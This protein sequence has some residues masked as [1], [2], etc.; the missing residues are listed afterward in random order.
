MAKRRENVVAFKR[1]F[2]AVPLRRIVNRPPKPPKWPATKP[3]RKPWRQAWSETR[4]FVLLIALVTIWYIAD[5]HSLVPTP[6]FLLT[7]HETVAGRFSRCGPGRSELCVIDGDTFKIG[8]RNVRVVG[9]DTPEVDARCPQEATAAERATQALQDWLNSGPFQMAAKRLD[10]TDRYGRE[11][12]VLSRVYPDSGKVRKLS[13]SMIAG[14][15]ARRYI[16]G[17]RAG[18]C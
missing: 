9:I 6:G 8:R 14:G 7:G 2:R 15:Y 1:P 17:Y 18:W 3:P 4:P 16:M 11:L 10:Q 12:R 13:D 5:E